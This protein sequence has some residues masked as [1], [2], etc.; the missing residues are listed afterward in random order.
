MRS[1]RLRPRLSAD[2]LL[3]GVLDAGRRVDLADH[4]PVLLIGDRNE[5]V[6]G[7]EFRLE[8]GAL[9]REGEERLLDF[10]DQGWSEIV[11]VA[12]AGGREALGLVNGPALGAIADLALE[13]A[14]HALGGDGGGVRVLD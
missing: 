8:R 11:G 6:L 7:L 14:E 5:A 3:A 12:V 13:H 1:I 4:A 2:G 9:P 10:L